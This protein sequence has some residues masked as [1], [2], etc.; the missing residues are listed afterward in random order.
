MT[1]LFFIPVALLSVCATAH[2]AVIGQIDNFNTNTT[3]GWFAGGG[4]FGQVPP[5]PPHTELGGPAGAADP[6]LVLT[7]RGGQG[8]GSRLVGMNAAQWAGNYLLAGV[9]AIQMDLRNLGSTDLTIRLLF[10][11]PIPGPPNNEV[12]SS[13]GFFLAAGSGWMHATFAIDPNA[14][15]PVLGTATGALSGATIMRII[16]ASSA[17]DADPVAGVL[18]VDNIT[19][20]PEPSTAGLLALGLAV[21]A[22]AGNYIRRRSRSI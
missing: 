4:P 7:S 12:V 6:F 3:E 10:E 16:H 17:G 5:V 21:A 9:T 15:T 20:S 18:G 22:I 14:F 1:R 11:D 19:A 8:P 2:A 13:N